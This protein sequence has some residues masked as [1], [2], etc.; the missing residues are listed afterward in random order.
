MEPGILPNIFN[1]VQA[2]PAV[3]KYP[4]IAMTSYAALASASFIASLVRNKSLTPEKLK[5]KKRPDLFGWSFTPPNRTDVY[6]DL[7]HRPHFAATKPGI[8][9]HSLGL[10]F[11]PAI[12][13]QYEKSL[14]PLPT[15]A[16]ETLDN[17]PTKEGN[18]V[19]LPVE[20]HYHISDPLKFAFCAENTTKA[21]EMVMDVVKRHVQ[22]TVR[23][24]RVE[25]IINAR[26]PVMEET[27]ENTDDFSFSNAENTE[28]EDTNSDLEENTASDAKKPEIKAIRDLI[29]K[30]DP[31]LV[32]ELASFGVTLDRI[33]VFEPQLEAIQRNALLTKIAMKTLKDVYE[34]AYRDFMK[35]PDMT[36]EIA[37]ER[38]R[39]IAEEA[40]E[41]NRITNLPSG[42]SPVVEM[43]RRKERGESPFTP[44]PGDNGPE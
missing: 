3:I 39:E 25:D 1:T 34:T 5:K 19:D 27:E 17:L 21:R 23:T 13:T 15:N 30:D 11:I 35:L 7:F 4:F 42:S 29:D 8:H 31:D 44:P 16:G 41:L 24:M 37:D 33:F 32:R 18:I 20:I 43:R 40:V 22:R 12:W 14:N 6:T 28:N 36:A 38:A 10:A 2:L 9:M 26:E